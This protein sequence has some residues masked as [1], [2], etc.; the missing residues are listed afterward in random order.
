MC[1]EL[2]RAVAARE[3]VAGESAHHKR[4]A[5][6]P[7]PFGNADQPDQ[8][9]AQND[10]QLDGMA[11]PLAPGKP[12]IGNHLQWM[13]VL[14]GASNHFADPVAS[15]RSVRFHACSPFVDRIDQKGEPNSA[16]RDTGRIQIERVP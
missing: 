11:G 10:Y 15:K 9:D 7:S 8:Q 5:K 14:I 2:Q 4:G 1:R 13:A 3:Q 16:G 12:A 6:E